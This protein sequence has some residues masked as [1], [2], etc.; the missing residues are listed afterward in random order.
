METIT[1]KCNKSNHRDMELS[2]SGF[3]YKRTSTHKVQG[4]LQKRENCE[5]QIREFAVGLYLLKLPRGTPP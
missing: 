2:P 3:I 5:S 4:T 1:E